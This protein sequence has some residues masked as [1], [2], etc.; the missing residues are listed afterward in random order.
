[1]R[2]MTG[3]RIG[4]RARSAW[5]NCALL[6]P[7]P[8]LVLGWGSVAAESCDAPAC[9][10]TGDTVRP[11]FDTLRDAMGADA[12]Y[13]GSETS[14]HPYD[15]PDLANSEGWE[16]RSGAVQWIHH[17]PFSWRELWTP[18][19]SRCVVFSDVGPERALSFAEAL[20]L[21]TASRHAFPMP[22]AE[23]PAPDFCL[24]LIPVEELED[25]R[26]PLRRDVFEGMRAVR[27]KPAHGMDLEETARLSLD[28]KAISR[29]I[30]QGT[31]YH[32]PEETTRPSNA[33]ERAARDALALPANPVFGQYRI[34]DATQPPP[35]GVVH[36]PRVGELDPIRFVWISSRGN[37]LGEGE[38]VDVFGKLRAGVQYI[39]PL[40]VS[41]SWVPPPDPEEVDSEALIRAAI[42]F[43]MRMIL[44]LGPWG[45]IDLPGG[46]DCRITE[47]GGECRVRVRWASEDANGVYLQSGGHIVATEGRGSRL[48]SLKLDSGMLETERLPLDLM[49]SSG[50][51]LDRRSVRLTR[52]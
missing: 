28:T 9:L 12:D 26:A 33:R 11:P 52:R 5:L 14:L 7:V 21:L 24:E 32:M 29:A 34:L 6:L 2:G 23:P 50:R 46:S 44:A 51:L 19:Q 15:C 35:F 31:D 43:R 49:D 48:L 37:L 17:R 18:S 36:T 38:Q 20:I 8:V 4:M 3:P 25:R 47:G 42:D 41:P 40:A 39:Y 16:V 30:L 22:D 1:M 10:I 27:C 45:E 13:V